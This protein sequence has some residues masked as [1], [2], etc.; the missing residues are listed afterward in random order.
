MSAIIQ[1]DS[2]ALTMHQTAPLDQ[3]PAVVFLARLESVNSR[4]NMNRYLDQIANGLVGG[5]WNPPDKK[6]LG[7]DY[8][9]AQDAYKQGAILM[10][11]GAL[12]YQHTAAIRAQLAERFAARTVN[13]MLSALRG[14]LKEAWRLGQMSA[15]DYQRAIDFKNVKGDD[16]PPAGRDIGKDEIERLVAACLDDDNEAAGIRDTAIIGVFNVIGP[17][18]SEVAKLTLD[19]Y[20]P[21]TG[22]LKIVLS[23]GKKTRTVYIDNEAQDALNDWLAIRGSDP[24]ALF[25][26]VNKSGK[27]SIKPMTAQAIYNMLMKRINEA[28]LQHF[29]P[30]DFRR[31]MLGD[32]LDEGIDL[33]TASKIMGHASVDTTARYDR[34][35]EDVKRRVAEKLHFPYKKRRA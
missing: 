2:T 19:D 10:Q 3:N 8:R 17:R 25:N 15:E 29:T 34:R 7:A 32:M 23:K 5:Q 27:I 28:G 6:A 4:R 26:P 30:H 21:E 1:A 14:V 24:G 31:T 12:R 9:A 35:S 22:L 18:R 33:V 16:A 13:G 11:W 20:A